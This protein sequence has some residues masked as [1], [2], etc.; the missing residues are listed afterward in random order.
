VCFVPVCD[1]CGVVGHIKRD[2]RSAST[3]ATTGMN[4]NILDN[5][6][7]NSFLVFFVSDVVSRLE[8]D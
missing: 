5:W 7:L 8:N 2:C 1:A 3:D 4:V 6:S